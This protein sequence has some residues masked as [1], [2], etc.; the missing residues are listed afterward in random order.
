MTTR[1][2]MDLDVPPLPP[3]DET[4][5]LANVRPSPSSSGRRSSSEA[6]SGSESVRRRR[7]SRGTSGERG[8]VGEEDGEEVGPRGRPQRSQKA[9]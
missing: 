1:R 3:P 8:G 7:P 4:P 5:L 2:S 9:A 6:R